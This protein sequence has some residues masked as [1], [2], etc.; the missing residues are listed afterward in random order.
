MF[1][2]IGIKEIIYE[3]FLMKAKVS[4]KIKRILFR[5]QTIRKAVRRS[6]N[7]QNSI[8]PTD[9]KRSAIFEDG[10]VTLKLDL[11]DD[12][13]KKIKNMRYQETQTSEIFNGFDSILKHGKSEYGRFVCMDLDQISEDLNK[14]AVSDELSAHVKAYL[15][16][17][18]TVDSFISWITTPTELPDEHYEFGFHMDMGDTSGWKWLNAFIYLDDVGIDQGPHRAVRGTHEETFLVLF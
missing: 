16:K 10:F 13:Y 9:Y 14:I 18:A 4:F 11:D 15:G 3:I 12:L 1:L 2:L 17:D 5:S 8:E 6:I 7:K